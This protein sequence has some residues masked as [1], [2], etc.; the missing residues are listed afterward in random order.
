MT[1]PFDDPDAPY[2]V[3]VNPLGQYSLW[4][5]F[6]Q[7]PAGWRVVHGRGAREEC[8]AYVDR[9]WTDQRPPGPVPAANGGEVAAS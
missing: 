1:S 6:A 9:V 8:L 5:A 4:P 3:L 7:V 2:L